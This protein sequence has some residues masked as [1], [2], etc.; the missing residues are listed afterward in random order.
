M[1]NG[2]EVY[3]FQKDGLDYTLEI[4]IATQNDI[5]DKATTGKNSKY[6]QYKLET[7]YEERRN[8]SRDG[9]HRSSD[10]K[11]VRYDDYNNKSGVSGK[12]I[13]KNKDMR[14]KR[15]RQPRKTNKESRE[16][17]GAKDQNH[18]EG[19]NDQAGQAGITSENQ[20]GEE[21]R[22]NESVQENNNTTTGDQELEL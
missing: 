2:E 5:K 8:K 9:R 15:G 4:R 10:N 1:K 18:E 11:R 13:S 20:I 22:I 12:G 21:S 6:Y 14:E 19:Q 3:Q 17:T 7:F 16:E